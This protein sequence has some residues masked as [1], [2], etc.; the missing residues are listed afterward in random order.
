MPSSDVRNYAFQNTHRL[1]FANMSKEWG[2][3]AVSNS[4]GAAYADLDNDGDLDLVVNNI[5]KPAFIYRN[6]TEETTKA[7]FIKIKL[8]GTGANPFGVGAKV[9]LFTKGGQQVWEQQPTRGFQSS[10]SPMIVL[11]SEELLPLI[12]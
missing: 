12:P 11:V 5:N 10:V 9:Q 2:F 3:D 6:N 1:Q 7:R 4:N 8:Q